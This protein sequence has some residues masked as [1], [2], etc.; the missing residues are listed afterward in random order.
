MIATRNILV[1]LLI[2]GGYIYLAANKSPTPRPSGRTER[3]APSV[4]VAFPA[5]SPTPQMARCPS[6]PV[7]FTVTEQTRKAVLDGKAYYFLNETCEAQW[8]ASHRIR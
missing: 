2:L 8:R 1:L 7:T 5:G 3:P 6:C 4:P